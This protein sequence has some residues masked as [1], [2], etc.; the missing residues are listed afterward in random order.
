MPARPVI[1]I[2]L[3]AET[4]DE[5]RDAF[6]TMPY[7]AIRQNYCDVIYDAGGMPL[8]LP[9]YEKEAEIYGSMLDGLLITGGDFD[10]DPSLY[11]QNDVHERVL[12]KSGRTAFEWAVTE[13]MLKQKKPVLGICGGQQLLNVVLGG[14]LFQHIPDSV[15]NALEH[16]DPKARVATGHSITIIENTLLHKIVGT[17]SLEVNTAHH[18]AV[19]KVGAGVVINA[20]APDGVIEGIEYP[21]H[22]FCLGVQWHPEYLLNAGDPKLFQALVKAAS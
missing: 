4:K 6:S 8:P 20:N 15:E 1:G 7:Y 3:D 21:D 13:Y 14:S 9:H 2:T 11:G 12:I 22:P 18:Q 19:D 10:I 5:R 17:T 16:E